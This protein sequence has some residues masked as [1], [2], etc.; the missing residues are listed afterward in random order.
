MPKKPEPPLRLVTETTTASIEPPRT[1][2]DLGWPAGTEH[3]MARM[4]TKRTPINRPPRLT[5]FPPEALAAFKEMLR[6][7]GRCRCKPRDWDGE[8]WKHTEC[9]ACEQW[10]DQHWILHQ[11]L[12]CKPWE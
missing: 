6:L 1:L 11:A 2:S 4:S 9:R 3:W 10:W 5:T 12:H 7:E 8:Y